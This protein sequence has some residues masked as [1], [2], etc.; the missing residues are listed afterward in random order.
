MGTELNPSLLWAQFRFSI[1]GPLLSSPPPRGEL[2][3]RIQRLAETTWRDPITGAERRFSAATI[4]RWY[5]KALQAPQDPVGALRRAIRKD[6]GISRVSPRVATVLF[7][8]YRQY[9]HWTYKLHYD[10]LKAAAEADPTL[11]PLPS[12]ATVRRF[13]KSQGLYR[14]KRLRPSRIP[15]GVV[16]VERTEGRE[17]RSFEAEYVGSL[18]HLDFHHGSRTVLLPGGEW[19]RPIALGVIDDR[20]RLGCHVQWYLSETAEVLVHGF[21]QAVQKR[22]LPRMVYHDQGSAMKAEEFVEGLLRLGIAQE[23]TLAYS[24]F[25]NGKQESFWGPLEGRLVAMLEGVENLTLE[26]LNTATQAW[27]ELEYNRSLH[28]EIGESPLERFLK[29]PDVLRPSPSSEELR[30][31]F[32]L[33]T[34]RK[35]RR[36]DGTISLEGVRYEIPSQYRHFECVCVRYAR[37]DLSLVHL[38]D[39]RT[40]ALLARIFP[41]DRARN[42][43]GFRKPLEP[44]VPQAAESES[45]LQ[46]GELPPLLRKLLRDY[47]ASGLPPAY[48]PFDEEDKEKRNP[49]QEAKGGEA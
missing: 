14:R 10:N 8:L 22:G 18:W 21:S 38:V 26:F 34:M 6:A 36:S 31:A 41:L 13:M 23:T 49:S 45:P 43:D 4:T 12:Y 32:R 9:P 46:P 37:W 5:Y 17:V 24:P 7:A 27:L 30:L 29:G 2:E 40:G 35:Q 3:A 16:V 33:E 44:Q 15:G 39:P 19:V 1:V 42:A 47:S 11:G 48:L 25:Q 28:R 20:S